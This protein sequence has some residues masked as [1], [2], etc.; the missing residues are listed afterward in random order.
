MKYASVIIGDIDIL[1]TAPDKMLKSGLGDMLA[2]YISICEWRIAHEI[3][4]EYYCEEI[5]QLV[6]D[7]LKKCVDNADGLLKRD[8]EAIKAVFEGLIICGEAMAYA[9]VSRPASGVEHYLSHIWDMRGLEFGTPVDLHGIQCAIG[10]YIAAGLYEKVKKITPD[11]DNALKYA[12]EFDLDKWN[13][14]LREF[15]GKGSIAMIELEKKEK[16]Y[17]AKKHRE[18]LETIIERWDRIVQIIDEEVPTLSE[19]DQLYD[20]IGLS[21]S[22]EVFGIKNDLIPMTFKASKDIRDKYV[23]SRLL[24]DLG[25]INTIDLI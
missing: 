9:G 19:L 18:R 10:T 16:K 5:A 17:D 1:K 14:E 15:L 6:R 11:R 13:E 25:V 4:G 3:T 20:L 22:P 8:D 12:L 7:S 24:W 23:L 2:K 21:K